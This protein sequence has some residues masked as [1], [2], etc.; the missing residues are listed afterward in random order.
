MV[1]YYLIQERALRGKAEI[2]G[3]NKECSPE[4]ECMYQDNKSPLPKRLCHCARER[5]MSLPVS[6]K[7]QVGI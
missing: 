4:P 1:I 6:T 3:K 5:S 2:R 7:I